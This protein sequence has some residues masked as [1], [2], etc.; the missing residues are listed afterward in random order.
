VARSSSFYAADPGKSF[1]SLALTILLTGFSIPSQAFV[2]S[3]TSARPVAPSRD[4]AGMALGSMNMTLSAFQTRLILATKA[5]LSALNPPSEFSRL[6]SQ[7]EEPLIATGPTS[8]KD[9]AALL[10]AL[11]TFRDRGAEDDF[12][13]LENFIKSHPHSA[14]RIGL[15]TNLGLLDYHYGYFSRAIAVWT[16]AWQAGRDITD[17]RGKAL[18]DRAIGE[19]ARMHARLGHVDELDALFHDLGDRHVTGQATEAVSG[20][21]EGLWMMRHDPGVSYLCGPMALKNL[22]L[23]EGAGPRQIRAIEDYRSGAKGTNLEQIAQLA[24]DLGFHAQLIYRAPGQPVP[25][26][27]I[28]HWKVNHFAALLGESNGRLHIQDPTFGEDLW[29]TTAALEAESSG[30]FLALHNRSNQWHP[31]NAQA[32]R[33]IHGMGSTGSFT[34]G[35]NT[36]MAEENAHCT[37]PAPTT[38]MCAYAIAELTASL[39]LTDTPVGYTPPKGPS[40]KVSIAYNEREDS[41]PATF[42][43]FNV[44]PKWTLNWLTYIQDD[45][46]SA[47]SNVTRY[48][49]GGGSVQYLNYNPATK[50][51]APETRNASVLTLVSA[52]PIV[53]QRAFP[54]GSLEVYSE[55]NGATTFPRRVFLTQKIDPAGN[56]VTLNYDAQLR[57]MSITDATGR[58]TTFSYGLANQP[59][60]VTQITDP[61]GRGAQ[62]AYDASARLIQITDVLGLKSRFTYD[63]SS[64]V[65]SLTTPYG[66]TQFAYGQATL[67]YGQ[68]P[69]QWLTATDPLGY[70]ERVEFHPAA[71]GINDYDPP[72][73]VPYKAGP[74]VME[75]TDSLLYWRNSFHWDKHAYA[76]A[77][78][79]YTQARMIHWNHWLENANDAFESIESTKEPLENRVWFTYPGQIY[80]SIYSGSLEKPNGI[81]R[82]LDD[83]TSQVT[84]ITYNSFGNVT[85]AIDPV[86]RETQFTYAA[87]G[88]DLLTVKQKTS[89]SGFSVIAQ[90]TYDNQH[91]PLTHTDA[92]GQ[93]T[94]FAYNPA[95][96]LTQMTD[97]LNEA[98]K[99]QYD[100]LGYLTTITNANGKTQASFTYDT[101]GRVA[102]ATDSEGY[103]VAYAYDALDRVTQETFP[104]ATT[105]KYGYTNLDL[106]SVT[107]R[108]G[109]STKYA[110]D[111]VRNL[112]GITDPLNHVTRL[113]YWENQ[114]LK[115]LTDPNGN[116]T[117]WNIDVQNR[118]TG[119]QYADGT[120]VANTYENTTSRLKSITDALEQIKSFGYGTDDT[121][122]NTAYANAVNPTPNVSFAYDPYFRRITSMADGNGTR[123]YTYQPV[124]SL[125]ALQ[126]LNEA[127]PYQND[128]ITYQYDALSRLASR[129][130][131]TSTETFAYDKLSRL[132]TNGTALGTF[133]LSYLGQTG[134][135]TSQQISAGTAGMTWT[136]EPN[137]ND[138]R[139]KAITNSG[140]TRSFSY[141]TTPENLITQIQE[142]APNGSAWAPQTW[143]YTYDNAYR[144]TQASSS[145]GTYAYGLDPTDNITSYQL[146]SG[147]TSASYNNL[148]QVVDFGSQP[149]SYDKNGN[150]LSDGVR[151][152]TWDAEDRLLSITHNAQPG[153]RTTFK[154]DGLG[155]RTAID[156][157][158]GALTSEVRYLWC[159][160]ALC[161]ARTS[162]DVAERRYYTEGEYLPLAGTSL[163]Y[164]RDQLGSVRDVLATQNGSG[165]ATFDYD[166]YGN[167][168]ESNGRISTDFRYAGLFY[169][170]QDGIH[171]ANH[172]AYNS[173]ISRWLSRDP[174]VELDGSNPSLYI[175]VNG[176]PVNETDVQGQAAA[177]AFPVAPIAA[178]GGEAVAGGG[179]LAFCTTNPVGIIVCGAAAVITIG[180]ICYMAKGGKQNIENEYSRK[181][182]NQPDPCTWL[183][184]QYDSA[185]SSDERQKLKM[186]Q[187]ALGCRR[188][189][190]K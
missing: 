8:P 185:T 55:S 146:P 190:Y 145:T 37:C 149:Y 108:Q 59:L 63:A 148:N 52:S 144:L 24:D 103:T 151:T 19:L 176:N 137:I 80:G 141:T 54:D 83:G 28:V 130:V 135:I 4:G 150:L 68:G 79:D 167:P 33:R 97:A 30:Y 36:C 170:K 71:P 27:S 188:S 77:A 177:V 89:T 82:V 180:T 84:F 178:G 57:L 61:F 165:V 143:G 64:L 7:F 153:L 104:D 126:L 179:M 22:L 67:P 94:T 127:G 73:T 45:P 11:R 107:D 120:L 182:R 129:T 138:R 189:T 47:G 74:T 142:T 112:V 181:A 186:A 18:V 29:I 175:Y 90:F 109:N 5:A 158:N 132:I 46:R 133:N 35:T 154:Y 115:S 38:G 12:T 9:D 32:A 70:T 26:P 85:D 140:A 105:R 118:V 122:T 159:G 168:S 14:W 60:L 44:S 3:T 62:L 20:A 6:K 102:T 172:R 23:A 86:N 157:G 75:P 58:D 56:A 96:Q 13:A 1:I 42:G 121:L 53:Y 78:G 51:F 131:D 48:A 72:S 128:S 166:P 147:N 113:G 31:V 16:Q 110:Y 17:L 117:T 43:W 114:S 173:A 40:V 41:Q 100:S 139:L 91:L 95:G 92:A 164:S 171:L 10:Q 155:R 169:D 187:K 119:K 116:T 111:A 76:I 160:D 21:R 88:I 50:S 152:Y 125:G 124:G 34:M 123:A 81:G 25:L 183:Q 106:T 93:T 65:N 87:N 156:T 69:F 184:S 49:A 162:A 39:N 101:Y 66:T 136:Y 161:Q 134:Q 98:T 15:L 174:I 2:T 163:Y 99:Y